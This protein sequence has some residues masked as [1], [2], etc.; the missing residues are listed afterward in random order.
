MTSLSNAALDAIFELR[1]GTTAVS[2]A[3]TLQIGGSNISNRYMDI[4]FG[5]SGAANTNLRWQGVDISNIFATL[6]TF[7]TTPNVAMP[8]S[9]LALAENFSGNSR[10][11]IYIKTDG[12]IGSAEN[13]S[14]LSEG[15]FVDIGD[16]VDVKAGLVSSDFEYNVTKTSGDTPAGTTLHGNTTTWT[17]LSSELHW[18]LANAGNEILDTLLALQIR[19]IG[20]IT[21]IDS[22]NIFI[23]ADNQ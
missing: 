14:G 7:V 8:V 12:N 22:M 10:A 6:G 19:E 3:V 2:P 18:W 17:T 11:D 1:Q 21:N 23:T 4:A 5:G 16:W 9:I 20:N 15:T 13:D